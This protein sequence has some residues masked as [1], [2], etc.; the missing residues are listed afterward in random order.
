MLPMV[1]RGLRLRGTAPLTITRHEY[2][3]TLDEID[4]T[5]ADKKCHAALSLAYKTKQEMEAGTSAPTRIEFSWKL[6]EGKNEWKQK[7]FRDSDKLLLHLWR[8]NWAEPTR[9]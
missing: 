8:S 2:R 9:R 1:V 7:V 6:K 5:I 3:W 4:L